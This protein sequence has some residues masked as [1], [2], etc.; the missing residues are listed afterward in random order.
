MQFIILN[1][2]LNK[3][4]KTSYFHQL[5]ITAAIFGKFHLYSNKKK[6]KTVITGSGEISKGLRHPS[7]CADDSDGPLVNGVARAKYSEKVLNTN[8][9]NLFTNICFLL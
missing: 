2:D 4:K 3:V 7:S 6:I 1:S 5:R 9:L 8:I